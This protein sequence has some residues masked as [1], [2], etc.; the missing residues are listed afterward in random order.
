MAVFVVIRQDK[1]KQSNNL[2]YGRTFNPNIIDTHGLAQRI[3]ANVSVK[4]SDVYAVLI[5]LAEVMTYELA[6]SN[7]IHLDRFGYFYP[8]VTSSGALTKKDWSIKDNLK[9]CKVKFSP[10]YTKSAENAAEGKAS[11]LSGRALSNGF[12]Y[13][14]LD[15]AEPVA[16]QP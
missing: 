5:E 12:Q 9:D 4:E 14:V 7:K 15:L 1:R 6:N 13:R 8:S 2:W 3:Q 10:E 16:P 11:G